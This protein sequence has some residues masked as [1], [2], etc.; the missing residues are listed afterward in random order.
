MIIHTSIPSTQ[1]KEISQFLAKLIDGEAF[2]FPPVPGAWVA[3]PR[4]GSGNTIE[5][6]P[7]GTVARPGIGDPDPAMNSAGPGTKPWEVQLTHDPNQTLT[8]GHHLALYTKKDKEEILRLGNEMGF[9][10]IACERAGIFG[11]I[12]LWIENQFMVELITEPEMKR[13]LAFMKQTE[14]AR[15]RFG[16]GV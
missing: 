11:V 3:V 6:Y 12:E 1:P 16:A 10:T 15:Q 2:P 5:V 9:R 8:S 7:L 14:N 13:Y 4:D